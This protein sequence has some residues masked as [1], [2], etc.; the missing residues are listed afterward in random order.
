MQRHQRVGSAAV[1]D[2]AAPKPIKA[3]TAKYTYTSSWKPALAEVVAN[4]VY[5]AQYDST[6]NKYTVTFKDADGTV[7][8]DSV[9]TY[10]TSAADLITPKPTKAA[11]GEYEYTFKGWSPAIESVTGEAVYTAVFDSIPAFT[12]RS[13]VRLVSLNLSVSVVAKE[14]LISA[15]PIGANYRVMDVQGRVLKK[16]MVLSENFSI[17]MALPGNYLVKVGP[18]S[19]AVKIR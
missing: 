11:S 9:Y 3:A 4:A 19:K 12:T 17:P 1:A 2:L 18:Y 13:E 15:A 10:G 16:G 8:K 6:L 14:I 5:V 7:L